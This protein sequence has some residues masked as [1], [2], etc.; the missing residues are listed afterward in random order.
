M[1]WPRSFPAQARLVRAEPL[2]LDHRVDCR[3]S[4]RAGP[5]EVSGPGALR[6]KR[7]R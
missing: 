2:A 5:R 6:A 1:S 7:H 3:V 4:R